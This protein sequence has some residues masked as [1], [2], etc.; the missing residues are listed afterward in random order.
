MDARNRD[1]LRQHP[2]LRDEARHNNKADEI[3]DQARLHF[4]HPNMRRLSELLC[5]RHDAYVKIV[6]AIMLVISRVHI[7]AQELRTAHAQVGNHPER[8][9]PGSIVFSPPW[10]GEDLRFAPVTQ[11]L[12]E[13][14]VSSCA[15][16]ASDCCL[17]HAIA[18]MWIIC[19]HHRHIWLD[20]V[21][22]YV[23]IYSHGR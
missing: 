5:A 20:L 13:R 9:L 18:Y 11:M 3:A 16:S 17:F 15:F 2:E 6:H 23:P 22:T 8:P 14:V 4:F 10:E 19:L 1:Y 12:R 7:V 21:R